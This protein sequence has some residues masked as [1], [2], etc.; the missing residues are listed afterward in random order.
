MALLRGIFYAQFDNVLGP[1]IAFQY[2]DKYVYACSHSSYSYFFHC[3]PRSRSLTTKT[4]YYRSII[5]P[6]FFDS[7]SEFFITKPSL[8]GR[9]VSM[10][11]H[12]S[13]QPMPHLSIGA[14]QRDFCG[15]NLKAQP[16]L[17]SFRSGLV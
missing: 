3:Y 15:R 6:E 16:F 13:P 2:P 14:L 5:S 10:Y 9:L 8:C 4:G 1:R 11:V 12:F 7:I 17:L